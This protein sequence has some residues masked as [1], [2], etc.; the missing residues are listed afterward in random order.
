MGE[1]GATHER[2]M[3]ARRLHR[4]GRVRAHAVAAWALF[5]ACAA[6]ATPELPS[7]VVTEPRAF[8]YSV[9]DVITRRIALE[10][11][12]GVTLDERTLPQ[13]GQ[14]G[15]ALEL[16]A[17][18]L[19]GR[20]SQRELQL[21]YQVF[22]SPRAVRPLELPAFTLG[23][24]GAPRP[25]PLRI[26]A[27]PIVVA[28]LAPLQAPSREGLGDLRPDSA[29]PLVDTTA[30]R[31]RLWVWSAGLLVVLGFLAQVYIGVPWWARRHRPFSVAWR[32][33]R[34]LPAAPTPQQRRAAFRQ[35]HEAMNHAG[36]EVLFEAGLERWLAAQPRF[37]PLRDEMREFFRRS[38]TEFFAAGALAESDGDGAHGDREW[39]LQFGRRCRDVERGSA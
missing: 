32:R 17:V 2:G 15:K 13:P 3:K 38:H 9:G 18:R 7:A 34:Q 14:R 27:W 24:A 37:A 19:A 5:A 23:F 25:Q 16:R 12:G 20:G 30:V 11:P 36:G 22:L 35:L 29:P 6:S 33:L 4:Y 26:D 39:L 1:R 31:T 10:L 21:D 8:G 28:P